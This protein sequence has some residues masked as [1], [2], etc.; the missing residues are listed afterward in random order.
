MHESHHGLERWDHPYSYFAFESSSEV[1][2]AEKEA[3]KNPTTL[4]G[5][6]I[7]SPVRTISFDQQGT[8]R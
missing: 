5:C 4:N 1:D 6:A 7:T 3:S 8:L 2:K